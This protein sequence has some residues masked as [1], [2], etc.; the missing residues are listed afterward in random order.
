MLSALQEYHLLQRN[1]EGTSGYTVKG[2]F[3]KN[4]TKE[5]GGPAAGEREPV[6]SVTLRNSRYTVFMSGLAL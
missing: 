4:A 6:R 3:V 1:L 5:I 2:M